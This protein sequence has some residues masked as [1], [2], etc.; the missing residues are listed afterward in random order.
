MCSRLLSSQPTHLVTSH[1]DVKNTS[2]IHDKITLKYPQNLQGINNVTFKILHLVFVPF[3]SFFKTLITIYKKKKKK[4]HWTPS[5]HCVSIMKTSLLFVS[6]CVTL[7]FLWLF[8][9]HLVSVQYTA[10]PVCY[11]IT[12]IAAIFLTNLHFPD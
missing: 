9:L 8:C 6:K 4:M 5:Y 1:R 10:K 12:A 7:N 3:P 11:I 2:Q